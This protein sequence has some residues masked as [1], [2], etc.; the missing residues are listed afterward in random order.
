M[1][2]TSETVRREYATRI[3]LVRAIR[4]A[5]VRYA[6]GHAHWPESI[7]VLA[8]PDLFQSLQMSLGGDW[9]FPAR[10]D[11]ATEALLC[12][13]VSAPVALVRHPAGGG[14]SYSLVVGEKADGEVDRTESYPT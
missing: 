1:P 11:V 9:D 7:V 5:E 12:V 4:A 14:W 8:G 13:G 6:T 2:P 3:G 10:Y